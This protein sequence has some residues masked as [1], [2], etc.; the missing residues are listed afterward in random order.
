M[1]YEIPEPRL[2][3]I[4]NATPF[5]VLQCDKMGVGRKFY[6]TVVVKGAF[7]LAPGV[8]KL[9]PSPSPIV[10][11]DEYWDAGAPE[12]SSVK[13][14]GDALLGK[15]GTDVII[16]GTVRSPA[17]RPLPVWDVAVVVKD[18]RRSVIE[19]GAQVTGP[20][21]WRYSSIRGWV[22]TDPEPTHEVPIRYE[23]AYGGAHL[24]PKA[25]NGSKEPRWIVHRPNPSGTGFFD[26][27]AMSTGAAYRA[28]QW[29]SHLHP[30][31]AINREVPL[32]GL[33]PIARSWSSRLK[34][35]GTYDDAWLSATRAAAVEGLPADYAADFDPRFFQC[36]HPSLVA[37]E[38]LR[39][40]EH[41]ALSGMV[42]ER[43]HLVAQLPGVSVRAQFVDDRGRRAEEPVPLDTVHVDLDAA[44][45][46]L[47]WRLVLDQARGITDLVLYMMEKR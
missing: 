47:T 41:V 36:A 10:L 15:P 7:D 17:G 44:T 5:E 3:A 14:A 9:A 35:A 42:A 19:H 8:L 18:G 4:Q 38:H 40:D 22:L 25:A 43:E 32:A 23:L 28:P 31:T 24:D 16:T 13:R 11:A 12:R 39:G 26:E 33:G 46:H 27:R 37:R 2:R 30:V 29:Q 45:V 34:Y 21:E 1:R 6:D 20:R